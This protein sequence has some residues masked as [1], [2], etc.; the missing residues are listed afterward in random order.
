MEGMTSDHRRFMPV[1]CRFIF[2]DEPA[3]LFQPQ[4]GFAAVCRFTGSFFLT[5]RGKK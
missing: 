1:H 4:R 5:L 2:F 3:A